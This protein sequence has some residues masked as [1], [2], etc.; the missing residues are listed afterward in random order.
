[1]LEV[2]GVNQALLIKRM[3]RLLLILQMHKISIRN[4][5]SSCDNL[6]AF[7]LT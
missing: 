6:D 5:C 7:K 2:K 4:N 3:S 1:M